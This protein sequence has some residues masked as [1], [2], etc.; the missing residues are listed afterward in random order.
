[1]YT[2]NLVKS[3]VSDVGMNEFGIFFSDFFFLHT[4]FS[5][6][7]VASD[8]PRYSKKNS[9]RHF[10]FYVHISEMMFRSGR[11]LRVYE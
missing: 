4:Y 6:K 8:H 7:Y 5:L 9:E 2:L 11:F 10:F 3:E 1:M